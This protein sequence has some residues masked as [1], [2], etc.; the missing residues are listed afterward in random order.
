L[1]LVFFLVMSTLSSHLIALFITGLSE[2]SKHEEL[3]QSIRV[4]NIIRDRK[5]RLVPFAS[6]K[7][8]RWNPCII[9][10]SKG[11]DYKVNHGLLQSFPDF[12]SCEG[13]ALEVTYLPKSRIVLH[14]AFPKEGEKAQKHHRQES[15]DRKAAQD[16][17][18]KAFGKY[19]D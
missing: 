18:R 16:E 8:P 5:Y 4:A 14:M 10:D 15:L 6:D 19:F 7:E 1:P 12:E 13:L 9:T 3:T 17:L 2:K 11:N